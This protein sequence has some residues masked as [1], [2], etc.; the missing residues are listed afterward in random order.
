MK[1]LIVLLCLFACQQTTLA[2]NHTLII[3]IGS[4]QDKQI[5]ALPVPDEDIR[6]STALAQA[7][8]GSSNLK[9]LKGKQAT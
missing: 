4:Y 6:K 8:H 9:V 5:H 3:G 1:K 7:T 2:A